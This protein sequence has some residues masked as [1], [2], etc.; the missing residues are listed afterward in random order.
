VTLSYIGSIDAPRLGV[1]DG[2]RDGEGTGVA[3][4]NAAKWLLRVFVTAAGVA[5][6]LTLAA[7]FSYADTRPAPLGTSITKLTHKVHARGGSSSAGKARVQVV[8]KS[9]PS[10]TKISSRVSSAPVR[11]IVRKAAPAHR[12]H[13]AKAIHTVKRTVASVRT[14]HAAKAVRT[15]V[16]RASGPVATHH[17]ISTVQRKVTTTPAR[18]AV[19]RAA[20]PKTRPVHHA[21]SATKIDKSVHKIVKLPLRKA[22]T[23]AH[24]ASGTPTKVAQ[25]RPVTVQ[26]RVP[27]PNQ[28]SVE[29]AL[30]VPAV[31]ASI[32]PVGVT[33]SQLNLPTVQLPQVE[34][35]PLV[36]PRTDPPLVQLPPTEL[37]TATPPYADHPVLTRWGASEATADPAAQVGRA[38]TGGTSPVPA[39]ESA[40]PLRSV[41]ARSVAT[42]TAPSRNSTL[43]VHAWTITSIGPHTAALLDELDQRVTTMNDPD[44][45]AS[46]PT[47]PVVAAGLGAAATGTVSSGSAAG[48]GLGVLSAALRLP[49]HGGPG[50][51]AGQLGE[52]AFD[53]PRQPGF[54]PD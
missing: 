34:L 44:A 41:I 43:S 21:Q 23:A 25:T 54:S 13:V 22:S 10:K 14:H 18:R 33:V 32:S 11:K 12:H 9:H 47:A 46:I 50:R 37:P 49:A 2:R 30:S 48:T 27:V 16:R 24:H 51:L 19:H 8:A 53:R 3:G 5:L 7:N 26:V 20:V 39:V 1:S 17:R 28:G 45:V 36:V 15:G 4:A 52:S 6:G 29:L 35:P 42:L 31:G 38:G 40:Y